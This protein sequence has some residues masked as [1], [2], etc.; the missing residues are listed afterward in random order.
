[1][2]CTS[3]VCG[4]NGLFRPLYNLIQNI[5]APVCICKKVNCFEEN[6]CISTWTHDHFDLFGRN[7]NTYLYVANLLV[8]IDLT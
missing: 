4:T 1:M 7:G 2:K 3:C 6:I 8:D 5:K